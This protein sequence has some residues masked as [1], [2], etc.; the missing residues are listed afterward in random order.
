MIR[1]PS[2]SSSK[3]TDTQYNYCVKIT[4]KISD[5]SISDFFLYPVDTKEHTDYLA[6]IK[7]KPM[8]LGTV[9]EKL[10][11]HQYTTLN[12]WKSDMNLIWKN[13]LSYNEANTLVYLLAEELQKKF[14][15]MAE[16]IPA[17]KD[18]E[19]VYKMKK[20]QNKLQRILQAKPSDSK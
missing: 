13:A 18:E 6:K 10:A 2:R 14:K 12:E 15:E 5:F 11:S 1:Q 9:S 19:W 8:D 17:S 16:S 7:N 20:I 4:K 3:M